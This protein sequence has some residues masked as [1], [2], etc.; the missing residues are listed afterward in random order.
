MNLEKI[1][2]IVNYILRK[3]DFTLNYT[4]LLKLLYI[5][6]RECLRRWDFAI[7]E[8]T[9]CA[10]KRGM[11]LSGLYDLIRKKADVLSQVKWDSCFDKKDYD[12]CSIV[13]KNCSY[14]ELSEAEEEILDEIDK[15]YHSESWQFLVGEVHKFPE[16]KAV[17]R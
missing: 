7:S 9:Y 1:I 12:L 3:Y 2:Q 17:E 14:D 6:D 16:W 13:K 4:K 11:V 10:M 5:A 8:D 15:K